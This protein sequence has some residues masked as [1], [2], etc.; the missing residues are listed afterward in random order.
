MKHFIIVALA[1]TY[2]CCHPHT[3]IEVKPTVNIKNEKIETINIDWTLD[4]MTSMMLIMELDTN[5]DKKFDKKE[6]SFIYENYF[7]SLEEQSFYT[8]MIKNKKKINI[9]PKNFKAS[10]RKDRLVYNFDIDVLNHAKDLKISFFDDT[11]FV[12]LMIE[13]EYIKINGLNKNM[14]NKIKNDVFGVN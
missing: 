8:E 5:G 6:N 10:I 7:S 3:F 2:A 11:L 14:H 9:K 12:G 1:L 13:K 4:E